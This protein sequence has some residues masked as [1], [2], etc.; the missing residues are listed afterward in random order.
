MHIDA[1][2]LADPIP[3][4]QGGP[5]LVVVRVQPMA[6]E[7]SRYTV[8]SSDSNDEGEEDIIQTGRVPG[9]IIQT[10]KP[11]KRPSKYLRLTH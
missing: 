8:T 9:R 2:G 3:F 4:G 11:S 1:S 5:P 10:S 6:G 7:L